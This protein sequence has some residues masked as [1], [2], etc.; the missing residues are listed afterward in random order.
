LIATEHFLRDVAVN[1]NGVVI[2]PAYDNGIRKT[3]VAQV[4]L[5]ILAMLVLD[6][7]TTARV[8]GVAV[9][10]FWLCVAA[11]ILRRPHDPSKI[12]LALVHWGF[13]PV[14]L[15]MVVRQ[16]FTERGSGKLTVETVAS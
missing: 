8:V 4:V 16:W 13:W 9:L 2:S 3:L 11:V 7:G 14:L 1:D 5:G 10:A 15:I 12:D 6:F